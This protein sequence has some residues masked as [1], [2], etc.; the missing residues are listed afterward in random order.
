MD[1]SGSH[2]LN[3]ALTHWESMVED[4]AATAEE[5]RERGW[6]A[7]SLDPGDVTVDTEL[8]GF[9]VLVPD[10]EF[11]ELTDLLDGSVDSYRVFLAS[12][13]GVIFAV[14][15]LEDSARERVA[16]CPLYYRHARLDALREAAAEAGRLSTRIR[17]LDRTSFVVEHETS[18]PFFPGEGEEAESGR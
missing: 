12:A 8:P 3:G 1:V 16:L 10:N 11:R 18:A 5:Y 13:A 6:E 7:L 15:A 14:V 4:M 2:P 17:T 9:N